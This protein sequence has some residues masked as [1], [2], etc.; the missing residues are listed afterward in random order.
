MRFYSASTKIY[1]CAS[2]SGTSL[3]DGSGDESSRK[4]RKEDIKLK[5]NKDGYSIL[6]SRE[7]ADR[8]GL[9]YK[10]RLVGRFMTNVYGS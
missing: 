4:Q 10:K 9:T 2:I 7:D 1:Q 8:Q 6:P 3:E 5:R